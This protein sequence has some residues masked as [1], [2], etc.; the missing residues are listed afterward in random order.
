[1]G[2]ALGAKSKGGNKKVKGMTNVSEPE[3]R[4]SPRFL[5]CRMSKEDEN[6]Q[7][8]TKVFGACVRWGSVS[9]PIGT[10][11]NNG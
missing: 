6:A 7:M 2:L 11:K 1:M 9:R 8:K 3:R 4:A 10:R 5:Q